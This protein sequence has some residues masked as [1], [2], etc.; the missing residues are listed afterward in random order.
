M[1]LVA[2][3]G[4]CRGDRRGPGQRL[5]PC[6]RRFERDELQHAAVEASPRGVAV[7]TVVAVVLMRMFRMERGAGRN[8]T[9]AITATLRTMNDRCRPR[10]LER[11]HS[12]QEENEEMS[13]G[14]RV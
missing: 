7:V 8:G 6:G 4:D 11:Q 9:D 1:R 13:H 5:R 2:G 14:G 3:A 10:D 12:Q